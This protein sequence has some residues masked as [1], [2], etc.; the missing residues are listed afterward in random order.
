MHYI[1]ILKPATDREKRFAYR[2]G[3]I[4]QVNTFK[5]HVAPEAGFC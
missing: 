2:K 1:N 3:D 4:I 5:M